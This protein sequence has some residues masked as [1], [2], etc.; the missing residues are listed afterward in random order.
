[1]L[2]NAVLVSVIRQCETAISIHM[3]PPSFFF[4]FFRSTRARPSAEPESPAASPELQSPECLADS[5]LALCP[6]PLETHA[7]PP[8]HPTP[9]G[10]HRAPS[11][12]PCVIQQLPTAIYFTFGSFTMLLS[13]FVSSSSFP[14]V[15]TSL[16]SMSASLSLPCKYVHQHNFSRF[17][18]YIH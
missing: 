7:H 4:F 15:S 11:C 14:A 10:C 18:I 17:H 9:L 5:R 3:S 8:P 6:L 16:F 1:M 12:G 13:Q 2:Y